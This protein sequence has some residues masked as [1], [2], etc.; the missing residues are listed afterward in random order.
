MRSLKEQAQKA[1][2]E[3]SA[4]G[5]VPRQDDSVGGMGP[6]WTHADEYVGEDFGGL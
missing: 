5:A 3:A 1:K 2:E 4:R 6:A